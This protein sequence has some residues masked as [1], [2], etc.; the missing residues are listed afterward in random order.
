MITDK[1]NSTSLAT[2]F[3]EDYDD[4]SESPSDYVRSLVVRTFVPCLQ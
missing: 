1:S 2:I 4:V 3:E